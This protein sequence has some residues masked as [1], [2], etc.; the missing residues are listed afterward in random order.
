[1]LIEE[2]EELG[3]K[4]IEDDL[5]ANKPFGYCIGKNI[6]INNNCT[7]K[8]KYC[9]LLEELGHYKTTFGDITNQNDIRNKKQELV[10]RRWGY[11]HKVTLEEILDAIEHN[12]C[13]SYEVAEFLG[14]TDTY[15][16]ECIQNYRLKY[17]THAT[18]ILSILLY[19]FYS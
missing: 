1:M 10:A 9:T 4:V 16:F 2:C 3:A 8:E 18:L 13:K 19:T 6:Y 17:G 14:V 5:C 15:F 7:N 11:E 12:C